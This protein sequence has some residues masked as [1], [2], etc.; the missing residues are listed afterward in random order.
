VQSKYRFGDHELDGASFELRRCGVRVAMQP[1]ALRLLFY[2]VAHRERAVT[3]RELLAV[4]WQGE[5][6]CRDSIKR[7]VACVR[8]ALGESGASQSSIRTVRGHG[9][10][11]VRPLEPVAG[12]AQERTDGGAVLALDGP[13]SLAARADVEHALE[14]FLRRIDREQP[15]VLVLDGLKHADPGSL[16]LLAFVARQLGASRRAL[17]IG[18]GT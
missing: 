5:T 14:G 18:T 3:A 16:S 1:K 13:D 7:A 11:F 6:V 12:A 9:Y 10:Q 4:L 8:R 17:L 2:L 15:L